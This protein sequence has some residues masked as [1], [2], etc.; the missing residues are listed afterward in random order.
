MKNTHLNSNQETM[1]G[2]CMLLFHGFYPYLWG[3]GV[4]ISSNGN[5]CFIKLNSN[6]KSSP[7]LPNSINSCS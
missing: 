3:A 5:A 2:K 4:K 1:N 7:N 6:A